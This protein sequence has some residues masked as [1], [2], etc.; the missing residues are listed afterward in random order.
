MNAPNIFVCLTMNYKIEQIG[1][2]DTWV[3]F[4]DEIVWRFKQ[5]MINIVRVMCRYNPPSFR[6]WVKNN[7]TLTL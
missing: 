7:G 2:N 3:T 4:D 6:Q 5:P 1:A